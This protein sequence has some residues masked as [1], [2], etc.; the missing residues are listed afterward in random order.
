MKKCDLMVDVG[1]RQFLRGGLI[2]TA[3]TTVAGLAGSQAKAATNSALVNYPTTKLGNV[4]KLKLNDPLSVTYPDGDAPGD[5]ASALLD[6]GRRAH[7]PYSGAPSAV[8]LRTSDGRLVAAG[9][10]E[11][12][13]FNPTTTA[14]QAALVEAVAI[15]ADLAAISDGWLAASHGGPVDPEPGFRSLLT[16]VA[17]GARAHALRWRTR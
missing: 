9:C 10:V 17:A 14:L 1:R 3:A 16:A 2:A 11:S 12:V 15:G 6:A 4:G 13:A 7:A 5:V 8:V